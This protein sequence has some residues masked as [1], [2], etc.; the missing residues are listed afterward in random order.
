[1]PTIKTEESNTTF[2]IRLFYKTS[3]YLNLD[4]LNQTENKEKNTS[5]KQKD[6]SPFH[7][8]VSPV[9]KLFKQLNL[10]HAFIL[11]VWESCSCLLKT[12]TWQFWHSTE[13]SKWKPFWR[14]TLHFPELYLN[15]CPSQ[16]HLFL[17]FEV[18]YKQQ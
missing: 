8:A 16:A 14:N 7:L 13:M 10:W 15:D 1:M 9:K 17:I 12:Y 3:S 4:I 2:F 11:F 5:L 18:N 6:H